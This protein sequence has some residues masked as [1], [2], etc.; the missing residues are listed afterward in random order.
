MPLIYV[1]SNTARWLRK[2]EEK[3]MIRRGRAKSRRLGDDVEAEMAG[4]RTFFQALYSAILKEEKRER[5][6]LG[7]RR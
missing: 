3:R 7:K 6:G 2:R 4:G 5:V 1:D